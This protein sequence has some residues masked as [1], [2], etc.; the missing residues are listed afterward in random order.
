MAFTPEDFTRHCRCRRPPQLS[1]LV[2][3]PRR[4]F[5]RGPQEHLPQRKP[6]A[7]TTIMDILHIPQRSFFPP[8]VLAFA[9]ASCL[10]PSLFP[11]HLPSCCSL[12]PP[13]AASSSLFTYTRIRCQPRPLQWTLIAVY[14]P[15]DNPCSHMNTC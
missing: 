9:D 12:G 1:S 3:D 4:L 10:S 11:A 8:Q 6:M 13:L 5:C 2:M 14:E 15:V 7:K